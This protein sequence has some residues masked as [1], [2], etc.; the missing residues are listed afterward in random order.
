[1]ATSHSGLPVAVD[2]EAIRVLAAD[3]RRVSPAAWQ[4]TKTS[5]TAGAEMVLRDAEAFAARG[6]KTGGGSK[7]IASSGQV[8]PITSRGRMTVR[9]GGDAAW[10]APIIENRGRGM[11]E[12]PTFGHEPK[13][14]KNGLPA[15]L[16]P[17]VRKNR[18]A[19]I[20]LVERTVG[21]RVVRIVE[22]GY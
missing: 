10:F 13:T 17:A 15:F 7:R 16:D 1:M 6:G 19:I 11:V 4:A 9:F 3:L 8:L 5:L 2:V 21:D 22:G 12:H 14:N 18:P 20:A